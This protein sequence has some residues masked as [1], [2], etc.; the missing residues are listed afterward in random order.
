MRRRVTLM[1]K[2]K[3]AL[4]VSKAHG[5]RTW[6]SSMVKSNVCPMCDGVLS[7]ATAVR[8]HLMKWEKIG[9]CP[10]VG[11][12][13]VFGAVKEEIG[14]WECEACRGCRHNVRTGGSGGSREPKYRANIAA[15]PRAEHG[16]HDRRARMTTLALPASCSNTLSPSSSAVHIQVCQDGIYKK[17][18]KPVHIHASVCVRQPYSRRRLL[19]ST[20]AQCSS[21]A[22]KRNHAGC[23]V[24]LRWRRCDPSLSTKKKLRT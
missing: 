5:W 22:S 1:E 12:K 24:V 23:G 18:V 7:S 15:N 17:H 2:S 20:N 3:I 4:H 10:T 13:S 11:S 6:T 19:L 16:H 8:N 14:G 9:A 21:V